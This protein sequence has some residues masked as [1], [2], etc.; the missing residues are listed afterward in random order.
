MRSVSPR[1][2]GQ[3]ARACSTHRAIARPVTWGLG[4]RGARAG[5]YLRGNTDLSLREARQSERAY[6]PP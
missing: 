5:H 1:M 6:T 3:L 2:E 4:G